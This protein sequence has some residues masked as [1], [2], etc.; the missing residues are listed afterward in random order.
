MKIAEKEVQELYKKIRVT[1][2]LWLVTI[3]R[4]VILKAKAKTTMA[5]ELFRK[6]PETIVECYDEQ[7]QFNHLVDD[8]E[9]CGAVIE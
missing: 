6:K 8:F 1:G 3:N 5:D 4:G 7:I 9:Y 2:E